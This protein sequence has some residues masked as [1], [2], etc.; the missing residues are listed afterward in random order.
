[1]KYRIKATKRFQKD[2]KR[3]VKH[4]LPERLKEVYHWQKGR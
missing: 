1:M 3:C 2:V 4:N